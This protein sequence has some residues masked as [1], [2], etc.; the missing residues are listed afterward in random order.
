MM[1]LKKVDKQLKTLIVSRKDFQNAIELLK[2]YNNL[3]SKLYSDLY[4]AVIL[5][6]REDLKNE[7]FRYHY[8]CKR[9]FDRAIDNAK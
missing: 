2:Q 9:N 6:K 5:K 7:G 8:H 3:L 1:V 4:N